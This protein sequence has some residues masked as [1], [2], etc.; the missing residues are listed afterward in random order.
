MWPGLTCE[1]ICLSLELLP[2]EVVLHVVGGGQGEGEE[3]QQEG[4]EGHL[5]GLEVLECSLISIKPTII[6][7]YRIHKC[8]KG[9][10]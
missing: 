2:E 1:S 3:G 8:T 7:P 5:G 10:Y 4:E 9:H 6:P